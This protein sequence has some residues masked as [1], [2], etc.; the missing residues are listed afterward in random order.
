MKR[1]GYDDAS[2]TER[3]RRKDRRKP[4]RKT[5]REEFYVAAHEAT[6]SDDRF[7]DPELQQL[8]EDGRFT[9]LISELKSGKEA[10]VYLV[11]GP[12][13]LMAAK[14]YAD[15]EVRSFKN[16]AIYREGRFVPDVRA[17]RAIS[18]RTSFGVQ[19]QQHQW[20]ANEYIQLWQLHRAG[21]PV[22]KPMVGPE[23]FDIHRAG[24]VV[25]MELIGDRD[26]PA[27][28]LSDVRLDPDDSESA[29]RQS[30]KI[31]G[32][33][34]A[35]GKAHGDLSTFNL[36]WW[37]G[38]VVL[39]DLPQVIEAEVHPDYRTLQRRDTDTLCSSFRKL[40]IRADPDLV[41][42]QLLDGRFL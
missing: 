40:G 42:M 23:M 22:P 5:K 7:T 9:G 32:Q 27:P 16:D 1:I 36:L 11:E 15:L 34:H 6:S 4:R 12:T 17:A 35:L 13:G 18:K 41:H 33:L 38:K 26:A 30:L 14:I 2:A 10:T 21:V 37:Q 3:F 29:F 20:V 25:L 31:A 24:R 19:A 39:I 28:R 8:Y